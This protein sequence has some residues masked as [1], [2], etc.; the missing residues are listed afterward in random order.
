MKRSLYL[1]FA[2]QNAVALAAAFVACWL[3]RDW[4]L[5]IVLVLLVA[6][7]LAWWN[8]SVIRR[9]LP[10]ERL[11][12][13]ERASAFAEF[14]HVSDLLVRRAAQSER[15]LQLISDGRE[16][17][18]KLLDSMPD[19]VLGVDAGGRI[20]WAN[21]PMRRLMPTISGSVRVG[22]AVV[23]TIR[24]P[25]VLACM[26]TALAE[27]EIAQRS[28][29]QLPN[30]RI[31]AVTA[32][33]I[34]DGGAVI[35]LND[36]TRVEQMEEMQK[37]FVANVSH[38]LRT[39]LTSIAGYV[40][41]LADDDYDY[42]ESPVRTREFL[43]AIAKSARRMTRLTEDLLVMAKIESRDQK[44]QMCPISV[45][46]L[47]KE[48]LEAVDGLIVEEVDIQCDTDTG[49][50]VV[51][52]M[53]AALQILTNLIENA[54]NYGRTAEGTRIILAVKRCEERSG[55]IQFCVRDFGAG[56][57]LEHRDK[58][59]ERFYRADKARSRQSGGTG[60]GLSIVKHLVEAHGGTIWVESELGKGS[61]FC[62]VLP[63]APV[64]VTEG[65]EASI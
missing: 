48:A 5:R 15:Q 28:T 60:L 10:A 2:L 32:A 11:L 26:R 51:A 55:W 46:V 12:D 50:R 61:L 19:L 27:R 40:E 39:P 57:A 7:A 22:H 59:F 4:T 45:D 21:E 3:V 37:Q 35:V 9:A 13:A 54:I 44:L 14:Q 62:F 64:E 16:Q 23:Q 8:R 65:A 34:S 17:L 6:L 49:L 52:D 47:L 53:F 36:V 24:E 56:I 43:A 29:L 38:E 33:P 58:I 18:E 42:D 30:G 25:E 20:S 1:R 31:Y 63:E 41:I